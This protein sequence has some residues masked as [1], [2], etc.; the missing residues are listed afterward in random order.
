MFYLRGMREQLNTET[1]KHTKGKWEVSTISVSDWKSVAIGNNELI[2]AHLVIRDNEI[3]KEDEAN[4]KLI[5]AAP[6]LLE[7]CEMVDKFFE[8]TDILNINEN[9]KVWEV[10][11]QAIKKAT[12]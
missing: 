11:Q 7:A 1:M 4:A 2:I 3:T 10:I 12:S 6:E 8:K 9:R 5:A